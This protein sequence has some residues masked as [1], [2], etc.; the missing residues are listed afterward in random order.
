MSLSDTLGYLSR[1]LGGVAQ[2]PSKPKLEVKTHKRAR[3][4][5]AL[6]NVAPRYTAGNVWLRFNSPLPASFY[7][8]RSAHLGWKHVGGYSR[9]GLC[10]LPSSA[11]RMNILKDYRKSNHRL[12]SAVVEFRH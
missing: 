1:Y 3:Q 10:A 2:C 5:A 11:L 4:L 6:L 12:F 7:L 9:G 8:Q